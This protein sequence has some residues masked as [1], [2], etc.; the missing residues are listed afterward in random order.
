PR[1]DLVAWRGEELV[2]VLPL[3]RCGAFPG[4]KHHVSMPYAVEGGPLG[5]DRAVERALV[6]EALRVARAQRVGRLELRCTEDL[7]FD[8]LA[9]SDLYVDFRQELPKDPG[10][11]LARFKKDERR[12]V[13]RAR[14]KLEVSEGPWY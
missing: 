13:R 6:D 7:G 8:D 1:R 10:D 14:E 12:L 11:V 4:K 3:A 9:P 2:G 5:A